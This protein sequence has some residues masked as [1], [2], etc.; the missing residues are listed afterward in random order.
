MI[1]VFLFRVHLMNNILDEQ[2]KT[3]E[4]EQA[5]A[6]KDLLAAKE[7]I[8][9]AAVEKQILE[10]KLNSL[11]QEV[12]TLSLQQ[13]QAVDVIKNTMDSDGNAG[14]ILTN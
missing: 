1:H 5:K 13:Q 4:S 6:H 10:D 9:T 3:F 14:I 7:Q 11:H 8:A 2:K 12:A